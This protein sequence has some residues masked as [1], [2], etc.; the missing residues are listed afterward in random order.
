MNKVGVILSGC[1]HQDGA[2]IHESVITMLALEEDGAELQLFSI[3]KAQ[4]KVVNHIKGEVTK[5]KRNVMVESGRIARGKIRPVKEASV[6][7]LDAVVI[8][9]GFG[10]ALNLCN[11]AE[12]GPA[13]KV[14]PDVEKLLRAMYDAKKPIGAV[15]IAPVIL[16]K[17][18]GPEKVTLTI[19]SDPGVAEKVGQM[20]AKHVVCTVDN[21]VVDEENRVVTTP[22]YMLGTCVKDIHGGIRKLAREVLRL[23]RS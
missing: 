11:F 10:A 4:T 2:E 9:G 7:E 12:K 21:C 15:C 8:P 3:D 20:G 5:E 22:A 1:G 6:D 13:M 18:F 17:V 14:D 16:A 23:V 19:G